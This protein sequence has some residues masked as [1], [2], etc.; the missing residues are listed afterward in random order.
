MTFTSQSIQDG[1]HAGK[2]LA[3]NSLQSLKCWIQPAASP[4]SW[5]NR[6]EGAI[7]LSNP[8]HVFAQAMKFLPQLPGGEQAHRIG[9]RQRDAS[10][11]KPIERGP[12]PFEVELIIVTQARI[13]QHDPSDLCGKIGRQSRQIAVLNPTA[14]TEVAYEWGFGRLRHSSSSVLCAS[15]SASVLIIQY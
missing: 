9:R 10:S 5:Q 4:T 6:E 13:L 1:E 11:S 2:G 14:A 7:L 12:E 15:L 3:N 8:N